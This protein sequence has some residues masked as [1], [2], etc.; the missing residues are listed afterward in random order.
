MDSNVMI[1]QQKP[2]NACMPYVL[3]AAKKVKDEFMM[4]VTVLLEHVYVNI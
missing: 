3:I 2:A 4:L 1:V